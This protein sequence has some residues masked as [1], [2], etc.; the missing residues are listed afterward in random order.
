MEDNIVAGFNGNKFMLVDYA[1]V[2]EQILC[3]FESYYDNFTPFSIEEQKLIFDNLL[4]V[5]MNSTFT[6]TQKSLVIV[7]SAL[8][9]NILSKQY[10]DK[11]ISHYGDACFD[12]VYKFLSAKYRKDNQYIQSVKLNKDISDTDIMLC[13]CNS[14]DEIEKFIENYAWNF[15]KETQIIFYGNLKGAKP[16]YLS[17]MEYFYLGEGQAVVK[18]ILHFGRRYLASL[19][20]QTYHEI[21]DEANDFCSVLDKCNKVASIND[22]INNNI[23]KKYESQIYEALI[24]ADKLEKKICFNEKIINNTGLK[25]EIN[26]V[27]DAL[28]DISY[29]LDNNLSDLDYFLQYLNEK[30]EQ[31][32]RRLN[33]RYEEKIKVVIV[34]NNEFA[35]N[36]IVGLNYHNVNLVGVVTDAYLKADPEYSHVNISSSEFLTEIEMDYI[37]V[38]GYIFPYDIL[39]EHL[40]KHNQNP[41]IIKLLDFNYIG[42]EEQ[43][44]LFRTDWI[45]NI[46]LNQRASDLKKQLE[47][48]EC[49]SANLPY[50]IGNDSSLKYP[51]VMSI[52]ETVEAIVSNKLSVSRFG[53]G[54]FRMM[55]DING[56]LFQNAIPELAE[57]LRMI[58]K[59]NLDNH[60]V[61]IHDI[62]GMFTNVKSYVCDYYRQYLN[63]NRKQEYI[64][65]DMG[66]KYGNS[67]VSRFYINNMDRN[68]AEKRFSDIK[69]IW[70]LREVVIIEGE[71]TRMGIGNDL[72]DNAI[73]I[74]RI[75][76]PAENAYDKYNDILKEACKLPTNT[77]IILALGPTAT[78]LAYDLSKAGYQA[79]DIGH[80]DIEYEWFLMNAQQKVSIPNKYVNEAKDGKG[81]NVGECLDREYAGQIIAIVI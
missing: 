5:I 69:R 26:E 62:Y 42:S 33:Y 55:F 58:V 46:Q 57:K 25:N 41:K 79:I 74:R 63:Y 10:Y 28:L 37:I 76:A 65:L 19:D 64:M 49:H 54:E 71:K 16:K 34:H 22:L 15:T 61:A 45:L 31:F 8:L 66:K 18:G 1:N 70:N 23:V 73:N 21:I 44:I 52:E 12:E 72:F 43:R 80:I 56:P 39:V 60:M 38:V 51:K 53:D 40:R 59:S 47:Y 17:Q 48:F 2:N 6:D 75:L 13:K 78:V 68:L 11:Q 9:C 7:T 3:D 36:M 14:P 35:K 32:I 24:Y 29:I 50:E 30:K 4:D 27:K 77:L 20:L 81:T 67:F